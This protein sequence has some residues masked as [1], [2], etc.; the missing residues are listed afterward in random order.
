MTGLEFDILYFLQSLHSP[1]MDMFMKCVTSL[2][3]KGIL[4]IATGVS[5]M[6]FKKSRRI[7]FCMLIS[8]A[9]GLLIGNTLLKNLFCR[10]RPCWVDESIVLLIPKPRDYSFPSGHT[11]ASFEAAV[12]IWLYNRKWGTVFLI[13]A[14]LIAF[15][16]M[17]L[18]VHFPTDVLAGMGLGILIAG[19][20]HRMM[21]REVVS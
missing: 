15:S 21:E 2:G 5:L 20:V 14:A 13:L 10:N 3:D 6:C 17:Y 8:L 4:W 18:F 9:T 19:M 12:S 11:L 16:R 1:L 7:G